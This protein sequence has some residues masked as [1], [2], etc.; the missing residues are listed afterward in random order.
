MTPIS[1]ADDTSTGM[2]QSDHK[3]ENHADWQMPPQPMDPLASD[4]SVMEHGDDGFVSRIKR[5]P[6]FTI[7]A[8]SHNCTLSLK[9]PSTLRRW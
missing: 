5:T 4:A 3:R 1:E 6:S 7:T 2:R 9:S 8:E